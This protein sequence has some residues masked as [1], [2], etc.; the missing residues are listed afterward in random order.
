MY[1]CFILY[2]NIAFKLCACAKIS[3]A[4]PPKQ[5]FPSRSPLSPFASKTYT[6]VIK[7]D[8]RSPIWRIA[9][10]SKI[11]HADFFANFELWTRAYAM[12]ATPPATKKA[13][14]STSERRR[15]V[16]GWKNDYPWVFCKEGRMF[17]R[18]CMN[19]K[20]K[21]AFAT[22]RCDKFKDSLQKHALT[23]E[24]HSAQSQLLIAN[25]KKPCSLVFI[26]CISWQRRIWL[27]IS[28]M[29]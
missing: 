10:R 4:P 23:Q 3:G 8:Y 7:L 18:F 11:A 2:V 5:S 20:K 9:K 15:F 22:A 24:H 12:E 25:G 28:S 16:P 14:V 17:C 27:M 21:N 1:M 29:I 13:K 19:V 26:P 6:L